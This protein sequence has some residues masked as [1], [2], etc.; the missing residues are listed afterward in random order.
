VLLAS[1]DVCAPLP[2]LPRSLSMMPL[3]CV[4]QDAV[5]AFQKPP[6]KPM[7]GVPRECGENI[8]LEL[9]RAG[10]GDDVVAVYLWWRLRRTIALHRKTC[11]LYPRG[12]SRIGPAGCCRSQPES[13]ACF[14]HD[15]PFQTPHAHHDRPKR[16][17]VGRSKCAEGILFE[18]NCK[19]ACQQSVCY[20]D[21]DY[22]RAPLKHTARP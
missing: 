4:M 3:S 7:G 13:R 10:L 8:Q 1:G 12:V 14:L 18:R 2:S 22:W 19:S 20:A 9:V 15:H 21:S 17:A 5:P 16:R 6:S 11:S